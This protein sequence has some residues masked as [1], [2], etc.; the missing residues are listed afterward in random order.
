MWEEQPRLKVNSSSSSKSPVEGIW[1][2]HTPAVH[3][4]SLCSCCSFCLEGPLSTSLPT[5]TP[6]ISYNSS[7][8]PVSPGSALISPFPPSLVLEGGQLPSHNT[9][10]LLYIPPQI[11]WAVYSS[12]PSGPQAPLGLTP[13]LAS[14][15]IP[16]LGLAHNRCSG[17]IK[18]K[19]ANGGRDP[20]PQS[21]S[22][23]D[24][25]I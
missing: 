9:P 25:V 1:A 2:I 17:N 4:P 13:C 11:G 10:R 21:P 6:S 8:V 19:Q 5:Q 18:P 14:V 24:T 12:C 15:S 20:V 22:S 7:G 16:A 3:T 23:T